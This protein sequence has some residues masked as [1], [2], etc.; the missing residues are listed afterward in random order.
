MCKCNTVTRTHSLLASPRVSPPCGRQ[1]VRLG[2]CAGCCP[3]YTHTAAAAAAAALREARLLSIDSSRGRLCESLGMDGRPGCQAFFVPGV[4]GVLRHPAGGGPA[5]PRGSRGLG[6]I[7]S[8]ARVGGAAGQR[9]SQDQAQHFTT[10]LT[11]PKRVW[12]GRAG[13]VRWAGVPAA[14]ALG[15]L[16]SVCSA[17]LPLSCST[18]WKRRRWRSTQRARG[19]AGRGGRQPESRES[20]ASFSTYNLNS[21]QIDSSVCWES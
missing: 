10:R 7:L 11:Q 20:G 15:A 5:R 6:R 3:T 14:A 8:L 4:S 1:G 9:G 19:A 2:S 13:G 18:H 21:F 12:R 16:R 17:T